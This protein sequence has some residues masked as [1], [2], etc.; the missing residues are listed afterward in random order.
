MGKGTQAAYLCAQYQLA[1]I[2]TGD[3][4]RAELSSQSEAAK[5]IKAI[6][7]RGELVPDEIVLDLVRA[8]V[9]DGKDS[10]G[11]LLDGFPRS[12]PQ[13]LALKELGVGVDLVI[14]IS[15]ADEV[16]IERLSQR[17]VHPASGR[18]YH[19]KYKPPKRDG[20][21]DETG[22]PLIQRADDNAETVTERLKVYHNQTK[23]LSEHYQKSAQAG[24]VVYAAVDGGG[25]VETVR[26]AMNEVVRGAAREADRLRSDDA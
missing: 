10:S 11:F 15:V 23:P 25:D 6:M 22:E 16:V 3:M 2:A 24:E 21:D 1:H 5:R 18:V 12:L 4:L 26:A 19:L 14:E 17:R 8:R 9:S 20:V 7:E 13:A